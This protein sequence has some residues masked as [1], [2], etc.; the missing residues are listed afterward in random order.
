M[1]NVLRYSQNVKKFVMVSSSGVYENTELPYEDALLKPSSSYGISKLSCEKI[2]T[3]RKPYTIWRPFHI[4]SPEEIYKE[5]SSHLLT[6][7]S[8]KYIDN[9]QHIQLNSINGTNAISFTWVEDVASCIVNHLED[10]RTEN[11]IFNLASEDQASV[12]AATELF[13]YLVRQEIKFHSF[14]EAWMYV[15]SI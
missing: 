2:L 1:L 7:L 9:K 15:N 8:H 4:V 11:E 3:L 12:K 10:S 14:P 5:G 6:N 13:P